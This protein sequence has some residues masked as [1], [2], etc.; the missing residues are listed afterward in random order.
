M[1]DDPRDIVEVGVGRGL[2]VGQHVGR[3]EDVEA[4]VLHRAHVE[5]AD[6]DDVELVEVIFAAVDL[7]VPR[8]RQLEAVHRMG[9]LGQVG[10]AHPDGEID[11]A[12]AHRRE[13]VA[14]GLQVAGDQ[15][16][17]IAGL[18]EGIVPFGPVAAVRRLRP[19]RRDCRSTAGPGTRLASPSIRTR[20]RDSTSGRSGKKVIR[21]KPSAS[22]WVHSIPPEA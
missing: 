14:V 3:V 13:A 8:H 10:L 11:L 16:E 9:G 22:H 18:G 1:G 21:R 4:L 5:I 12:P 7:L 19:R 17:Q 20:Y 2:L 6:R 15:R